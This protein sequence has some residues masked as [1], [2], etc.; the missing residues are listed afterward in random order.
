MSTK[1]PDTV[2]S[3]TTKAFE[4]ISTA[5][6][7]GMSASDA[8]SVGIR[9]FLE[10]ITELERERDELAD[11]QSTAESHA[12]IAQTGLVR[13]DE[14]WLSAI[15]RTVTEHDA[16][17]AEVA[18][19]QERVAMLLIGLTRRNAELAEAQREL[20][21]SEDNC[22]ALMGTLQ[23][24]RGTCQLV[25]A[26]ADDRQEKL[27]QLTAENEA[28]IA[29]LNEATAEPTVAPRSVQRSWKDHFI[30]SVSPSQPV[31]DDPVGDFIAGAGEP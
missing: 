6:R 10:E 15:R 26:M 22:K 9:P 20:A 18:R 30:P 3:L 4:L 23:T 11:W 8:V 24:A 28:L 27:T 2:E 19:L 17:K 13:Q 7:N 31:L 25:Q 12:A 16:S 29:C 1:Q 5:Q 14:G 21:I